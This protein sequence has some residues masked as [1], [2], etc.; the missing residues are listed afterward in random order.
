MNLRYIDLAG[1][2]KDL[3]LDAPITLGRSLEANIPLPDASVSRSHA[4]IMAQADGSIAIRDLNS[5]N[6]IY[7]NDR[8]IENIAPLRDGA[9]V[10]IGELFFKLA[11]SPN[12]DVPPT[13]TAI[14]APAPAPA[15]PEA[16]AAAPEAAP[17][18]AAEKPAG[19]R[20]IVI[21]LK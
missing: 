12:P 5:S 16:P 7:V 2:S 1:T 10:Q 19:P 6:G 8:R 11:L 13:L 21:K 20:K 3:S 14:P 4:S 9:K 15:E 17:A 18:P